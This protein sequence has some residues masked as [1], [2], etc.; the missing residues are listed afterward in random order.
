MKT[1]TLRNA[2]GAAAAAA[3]VLSLS[4]CGGGTSGE[5]SGD[6]EP[7][8]GPLD[9]FFEE[10]YG[11]GDQDTANAQMMEVEEI[12]ASCMQEQGFEYTPV[13]YSSMNGAID[14][15]EELDVEW[16]TLEF[17]EQYGYGATTNPWGDGEE[18][19][20]EPEEEWVDPNQD[21]VSSMSE[22]EQTAYYEALYGKQTF[23]ESD[24]EAE[25]EYNWETAGCQGRAQHEVYEAGTGMDSEEFTALQDEMSAMWEASAADSRLTE[26]NSTWADCMAEA[27]FTGMAAVGDGETSIYDEVNALWENAYTDAGEDM[28]EDDYKA[29]EEGIQAQL[30]EITPREIDTAVADFTCREEIKYDEVQREV[31]FEYQ[32]KFVDE[33][34]EELDAWMAAAQEAQG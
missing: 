5:K 24:P 10:I 16:G 20:P 11:G 32:Q 30:A 4:A 7:A 26:L 22:T 27:G 15:A 3:L 34:R 12:V 8:M 18:V 29:I 17:A 1:L 9:T 21:Y 13:D 6:D 31:N 14:P 2:T 33:H 25:V 23:D 19:A 28:T